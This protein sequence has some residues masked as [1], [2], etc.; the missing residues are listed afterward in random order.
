VKTIEEQLILHEGYRKKPYRCTAGY[1][2]IGVGINLDA[3][4]DDEEIM[5]LLQHRLKKIIT[6]LEQFEWYAKLNH[7]RQKVL[8]DM[9]Y[10]LGMAGLLKFKKMIAAIELGDY[11]EA[12][13]QMVHSQWY[14]QVKARGERLAGMM[15][16]GAD[17]TD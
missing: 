13:R 1:L 12:A 15:L 3:G 9:A 16:T 10:N 2:T 17:Y 8:I 7:V 6:Q 4:L 14:K 5:F 11:P